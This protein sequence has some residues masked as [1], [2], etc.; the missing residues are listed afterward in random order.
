MISSK[1]KEEIQ[2]LFSQTHVETPN[3]NDDLKIAIS[4]ITDV[5]KHFPSAKIRNIFTNLAKALCSGMLS[6]DSWCFNVFASTVHPFN[7]AKTVRFKEI[8]LTASTFLYYLYGH[9]V[10]AF[11]QKNFRIPDKKTIQNYKKKIDVSSKKTLYGVNSTA[12]SKAVEYCMKKNSPKEFSLLTN[13]TDFPMP[14]KSISSSGTITGAECF[15]ELESL[16]YSNFSQNDE[17]TLCDQTRAAEF[18]IQHYKALNKNAV[19]EF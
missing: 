3:L 7:S 11:L 18:R 6:S 5:Y 1:E 8:E 14:K 15:G 4:S 9:R 13:E 2:K 19:E 17:N 10:T 12:I 16:S